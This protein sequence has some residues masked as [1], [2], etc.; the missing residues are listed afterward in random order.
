MQ[1]PV[2]AQ[3]ANWVA[4]SRKPGLRALA[5][6][7]LPQGC[8]CTIYLRQRHFWEIN[9]CMYYC[10]AR[11]VSPQPYISHAF[12][13]AIVMY[14]VQSWS[15]RPLACCPH[16]RSGAL[17]PLDADEVSGGQLGGSR[18]ASGSD[19]DSIA[20]V[21]QSRRSSAAEGAL[22]APVQLPIEAAPAAESARQQDVEVIP[23]PA[24]Q[25]GRAVPMA[26]AAATDVRP[27]T[28]ADPVQTRTR[29]VLQSSEAAMA[30]A[31]VD[32]AVQRDAVSPQPPA[33][34]ASSVPSAQETAEA[35]PAIPAQSELLLADSAGGAMDPS[36][37]RIIRRPSTCASEPDISRAVHA[38]VS[39][40]SG[41]VPPFASVTGFP[42]Q[43][44]DRA[45]T[46]VSGQEQSYRLSCDMPAKLLPDQ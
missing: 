10:S 23:F 41:S 8:G 6:K 22:A 29:A 11:L 38:A 12:A 16:G 21:H 35:A 34:Q 5:P 2:N 37:R 42:A 30:T 46:G 24:E 26:D 19:N 7:D 32:A 43:E 45:H 3:L 27:D 13:P 15:L 17:P 20:A 1:G 18:R 14:V 25:A 31:D 39:A 44:T 9:R 40:R 36:Q 33:G 28:D 4:G